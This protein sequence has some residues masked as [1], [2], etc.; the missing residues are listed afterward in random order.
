MALAGEVLDS[1]NGLEAYRE[2]WDAL[3]E[4]CG[5]PFCSPSWTLSWWRNVPNSGAALRVVV[6]RD[7]DELVAIAP[8]YAECRPGRPTRY[9]LL[10]AT[11]S[12]RVEPLVKPGREQEAAQTIARELGKVEPRPDVIR[13][14][15]IDAARRWPALLTESWPG[16]RKPWMVREW[17]GPAPTVALDGTTFEAWMKGKSRNFRSQA[18]RMRRRLEARGATF[19]VAET[20]EELQRGLEG[21]ARLHYARWRDRGG[22]LALD[23]SIE[24]ALM[25]AGRE[26]LRSGRFRLVTIEAEG[27]A[28]SAHLF[29]AAGGEVSYW[30][31]G[32]DEAWAADQPSMRALVVAIEDA[33]ARSD[34]RF[35]L[36]G[37]AEPYKYRLADGEDLLETALVVPR[38][39]RYPLTRLQIAPHHVRREVARRLPDE[40]RARVRNELSRVPGLDARRKAG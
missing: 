8:F 36:G 1:P 17:S 4:E 40:V 21:L 38:G 5:L 34:R 10:S 26:L 35:D 6:V 28:I 18:G 33:F 29:V 12:H 22:S 15:S 24:R 39:A 16:R 2:S 31:G 25:E 23:P 20:E 27:H 32:F 19:R 13:F 9:R 7:G 30:N 3:S 14:E 37:G 11:T